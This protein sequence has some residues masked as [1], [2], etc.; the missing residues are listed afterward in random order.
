M[1]SLKC[2]IVVQSFGIGSTNKF[3]F[4][5]DYIV[6]QLA[7]E[8]PAYVMMSSDY[9][10][11]EP[12][13]TA[14]V[15]KDPT[16]IKAFQDGR[17][18][19]AT[20]ASEA[21]NVPYEECLE[22]HPETHQ[23]Q[24]EGKKRRGEAK[25]IVLGITYGRSIPSIADQLYG[26]RDDM[27]EEEK[28]KGAKHVYDSV[29]KAFP[30]LKKV[31]LSSQNFCRKHGFTETILGRRRHL[32]DMTLKEFE[33]L[34]MKGYVNPDIDPFD[35]NSIGEADKIPNRIVNALE[36]EFKSFKYFGQI[37]KRTNELKAEKIRVVNNRRKIGGATRQVLNCVDFDTEI[38]TL[39]GWKHHWDL[40]IGDKILSYNLKDD[41]LEEDI[42][43]NIYLDE[44]DVDGLS[45]SSDKLSAVCTKNHRW[46]V[47]NSLYEEFFEYAGDLFNNSDNYIR[48]ISDIEYKSDTLDIF[49]PKLFAI[50]IVLL[51]S[52]Q[53]DNILFNEIISYVIK[54]HNQYGILSDDFEY[55]TEESVIEYLLKKLS[56][57]ELSYL[58]LNYLSSMSC[59]EIYNH[60]THLYVNLTG[61]KCITLNNSNIADYVQYICVRAGLYSCCDIILDNDKIKYRIETSTLSSVKI[62]S[63]TIKNKIIHG[64]WCVT[65][66]NGTWVAR[67]HGKVYITG[68]SI[69][70]GSA[71]DQSKM[72]IL[73]I[74][75]NNRWKEIG[76]RILTPI[77]DEILAEVPMEYYE[78]GAQLLSSLMCKAADFLPFESKCD[79]EITTRWYGLEFPCPYK[80][81][82]SI[83]TVELDEVKW[84][85]YHL[86]EME[87]ILP[88]RPD[89][90]GQTLGNASRGVS[91]QRTE[92][93]EEAIFD[94][95]TRFH[96]SESEFIDH[97]E[98]K[99]KYGN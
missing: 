93:M 74:E 94:Y 66:N 80:K 42:I 33:F 36:K 23:Y 31:M 10:A 68:N 87:Y 29:I 8:T 5:G 76:G 85:Q 57:K 63:L 38:L 77:H 89:E 95:M 12:R 81:A 44:N 11:Q 60:M 1:A 22:F 91:G 47:H 39:D 15:S 20:I 37:V 73:L 56:M 86:I 79:V 69:I 62:S 27:T 55:L 72:A 78:E 58:K 7:V 28:L 67:R 53:A 59:L 19:Y 17:D 88:V 65:T 90:T 49:Y 97:I 2:M 50:L 35:P 98:Q 92:E 96:V 64:V 75:N 83:D 3:N 30:N 51:D 4:G 99:V 9:S 26:K 24:K 32:P 82:S 25:I 14:F 84:I 21:F 61:L 46:I 43:K 6:Y 52:Q 18:I 34:P 70:Q 40:T 54:N 16:M 41:L 45:I 13:I 71:A 48:I